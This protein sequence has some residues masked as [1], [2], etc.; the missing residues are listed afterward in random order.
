M[1]PLREPWFTHEEFLEREED[2]KFRHEY[3]Q[4]RIEMI[5]GGTRDH[6]LISSNCAGAL[7]TALRSR[8]CEVHGPGLL[9]HIAAANRSTYPDA[10]VIC[11]SPA[12]MER[13][14]VVVTN[15]KVVIEVASRSTESYDRTEKFAAYRQLP[16][17]E[18]FVL[19]SQ[20]EP[21]IEVFSRGTGWTAVKYTDLDAMV[22]LASLE[23]ELSAREIYE[24]VEWE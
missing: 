8:N 24:R 6:S 10:F 14:K 4:G 1:L 16:S 5:A 11:G 19:I 12:Y 18:E 15:P 9:V 23:I 13:R 17:L 22:K 20:T 2:S 7:G 3:N 21:R